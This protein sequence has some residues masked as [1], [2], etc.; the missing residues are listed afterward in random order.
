VLLVLLTVG[1]QNDASEVKP[2]SGTKEA[3]HQANH[4]PFRGSEHLIDCVTE[5]P[6]A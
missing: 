2:R 6:A 4:G 1:V 5:V 3:Q